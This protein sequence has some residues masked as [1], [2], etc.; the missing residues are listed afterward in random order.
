MAQAESPLT[1][2]IFFIYA[3]MAFAILIGGLY[4]TTG[5][6]HE[7]KIEVMQK[8]ITDNRIGNKPI[9]IAN[10]TVQKL[11]PN[12][13][14]RFFV[15][16][17]IIKAFAFLQVLPVLV[18]SV[19]IALIDISIKKSSPFYSPLPSMTTYHDAKRMFPAFLVHMPLVYISMPIESFIDFNAQAIKFSMAAANG[20]L[21]YHRLR[22][23]LENKPAK[24]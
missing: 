23:L 6:K 10:E 20:F 1:D 5:M 24:M 7:Q 3:V 4:I 13:N 2:Q 19:F 21:L 22:D 11:P 14:I 15:S 17:T 12:P 18:F 9:S 16:L 8:V